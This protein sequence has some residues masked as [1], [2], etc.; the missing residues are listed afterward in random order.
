MVDKLRLPNYI[1]ISDI[2]FGAHIFVCQNLNYIILKE[3]SNDIFD[4]QI[5][6]SV[7]PV[8]ATDQLVKIF[9]WFW[10]HF[11]RDICIP[12]SIILR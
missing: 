6:S 3:Q 11:H 5:F 10:F 9:S 4:P 8:W 7:E 1:S 2:S 12:H